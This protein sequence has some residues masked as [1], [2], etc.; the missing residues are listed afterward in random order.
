MKQ[1]R[2]RSKVLWSA[3]I[4]QVISIGQLVGLWKKIG[5]DAGL[6]GDVAAGVLQL[7]VIFGII[8]S[9]TNNDGL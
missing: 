3:I 2:W 6:I 9:P 1:S 5:I 7:F 4:A 8:N